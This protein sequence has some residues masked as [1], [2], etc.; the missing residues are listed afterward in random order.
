MTRGVFRLGEH[1]IKPRSRIMFAE[2]V[3]DW[4][5]GPEQ[6]GVVQ[7]GIMAFITRSGIGCPRLSWK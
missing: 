5:D 2:Q 1:Y 7:A 4:L 6:L 3:R